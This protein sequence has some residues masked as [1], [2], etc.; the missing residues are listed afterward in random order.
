MSWEIEGTENSDDSMWLKTS[1]TFGVTGWTL[2]TTASLVVGLNRNSDFADH[3][4][5]FT[6]RFPNWF[7]CFLANQLGELRLV[8]FN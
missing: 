3:G 2:G 6:S 8:F 4:T 1:H 5:D 7:A